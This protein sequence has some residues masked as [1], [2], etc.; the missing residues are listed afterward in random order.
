MRLQ[1]HGLDL[2][3][4]AISRAGADGWFTL[5]VTVV[6]PGFRGDYK[7]DFEL[8]DL[9]RF[10][11]ELAKLGSSVGRPASARLGCAEPGLQL[12]FAMNRVGQ[13]HGRFELESQ[14]PDGIPTSL[15]GGFS[16]DQS[17]LP[18]L[19]ASVECLVQAA[20]GE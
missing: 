17:F 15:V 10:R 3:L 2:T 20:Q 7:C 6:V 19:R 12:D 14:R 4:A 18:S 16:M 9:E 13:I 1:T 8:N 11:G 5:Q